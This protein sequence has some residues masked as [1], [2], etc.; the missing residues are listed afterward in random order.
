MVE[1]QAARAAGDEITR[2]SFRIIRSR[3]G[4]FRAPE[5]EL[6]LIIRVAHTTGDVD[7]GKT[8]L[9][10]TEAVE[11]GI[12][13]LRNGKPV[14]CDV[15]MVAAGLRRS[16]LAALGS[17]CACLLDEAETTEL[18]AAEGL[19]RSAAAFRRAGRRGLLDGAVV[20][21]GNA[22]TALFELLALA[23]A[24]IARP[25]LVVGVPVGFVGALESKEALRRSS[26]THITNLGERGGSPIAAALVNGLLALALGTES[27]AST[28]LALSQ[29][30]PLG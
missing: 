10:S 18:A 29:E 30:R 23:E 15:G 21:V 2:E 22:P 27:E 3:L 13:A 9:F 12:R 1:A 16:Q 19:T 4:S 6:E 5:G 28:P 26:L 17:Q 8:I 7:F 11:S 20:A 25:A 14:V 24:G